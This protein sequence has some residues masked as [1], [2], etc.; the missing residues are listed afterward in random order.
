[1]SVEMGT[2]ASPDCPQRYGR[3][4]QLGQHHCLL[5]SVTRWN[6]VHHC[7]GEPFDIQLQGHLHC[8]NGRVL[9]KGAVSRESTVSLILM[10]ESWRK[11]LSN[12]T[13][14]VSTSPSSLIATNIDLNGCG[15]SSTLWSPRLPTPASKKARNTY[16]FWLVRTKISFVF[17][18]ASTHVA[19]GIAPY[20]Q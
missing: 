4:K 8:K 11:Y 16:A 18:P 13:C 12:G 9:V 5:G 14:P 10:P 3:P 17:M 2:L 1:M 7:S 6:F 15:L 19:G 20:L